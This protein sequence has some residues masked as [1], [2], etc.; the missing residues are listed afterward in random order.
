MTAPRTLEVR[1]TDALDA[2]KR[3]DA[4]VAE[5]LGLFTRSQA[6]QRI[7]S[8]TLNGH[9][10]RLGRKVRLG[11]VVSLVCIDPPPLTITAQEIPIDVLY[12]N[13]E[14][15]VIDKKQGMV[16]HPGSGN[17]DGT[18][19]NALLHH[20]AALAGAFGADTPRPGIVHRLD[21]DTSGIII[22]AKNVRAHELLAAQFKDRTVR[23][24]YLAIVKG[25]LPAPEGRLETRL[26]RDPR[27]RQRFTVVLTGGKLAVTRYRV[28]SSFTLPAMRTGEPPDSYSLVLCMPRTGRTHQLR[29]H[30]RHAGAWILGDALYGR[31]DQRFPDATLMLHARSLSVRLPGEAEPRV[32]TSPLP[33]R[34]RSVLQR[35]QSF[36]PR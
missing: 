30:L 10:T 9:Q 24:R 34:F 19:V 32:F 33:E 13:A 12:E 26:A 22:A 27:N 35:L 23:K 25:T 14:V 29:V 11:D 15:I 7:Q 6:R 5:R 17:R 36:S 16:V 8:L 2:G 3:I 1:V 20:C 28:L 21:K 31:P 18:L 4:L